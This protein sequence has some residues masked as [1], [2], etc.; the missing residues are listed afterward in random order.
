MEKAGL[1][2]AV[3]ALVSAFSGFDELDELSVGV[4]V[5]RGGGG[6]S[7]TDGAGDG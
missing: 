7:M 2:P 1:G 4:G 6:G 3:E 5:G